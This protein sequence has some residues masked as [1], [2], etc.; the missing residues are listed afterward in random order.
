VVLFL[1]GAIVV[2]QRP[3]FDA[4][5]SEVAASLADHRT[6]IQVGCAL[7]AAF[8][9]FVVWFLATVASL[10]RERG[11]AA[12]RAGAVAYG[13]GLAFVALFLADVSS[14]AVGALR[15]GDMRASPELAAALH[16]FEFL[17]M[18]VAAPLATGLLIA[19]AVIAR[20]GAGIWPRWLGWLAMAAAPV[21][22]L[23]M[24]TIFT[25]EGP[26]AADGVL[27]LWLPVA[28]LAGWLFLASVTLARSRAVAQRS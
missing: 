23:R 22:L 25:T 20:S 19:C 5:G 4:P 17:A 12:G 8:A 6:R 7:L 3:P 24:G 11:G 27:G 9:P 2:G 28:A 21:Y 26:F 13:C 14:L 16:D 15:P 1:A 18:G 10:A